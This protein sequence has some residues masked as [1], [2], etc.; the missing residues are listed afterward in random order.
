M[1]EFGRRVA[2]I[3]E[4]GGNPNDNDEPTAD[5][6]LDQVDEDEEEDDDGELLG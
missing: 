3:G 5:E 6:E 4:W 1:T 2:E